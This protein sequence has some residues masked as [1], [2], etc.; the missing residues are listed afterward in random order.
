MQ[1]AL[2][3]LRELEEQVKT[4]PQLEVKISILTQQKN[5]LVESVG[6]EKERVREAERE[7]GK[8]RSRLKDLDVLEDDNQKLM[9]H[10]QELESIVDKVICLY[11]VA[12]SNAW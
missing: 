4:I 7:N 9:F 6:I 3:R 8:L 5:Q 2:V 12:T 1:N 10:I 11:E